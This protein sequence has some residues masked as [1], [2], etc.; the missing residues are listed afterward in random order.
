MKSAVKAAQI[1]E[2]N[3]KHSPILSETAILA[4]KTHFTYEEARAKGMLADSDKES[5]YT[6]ARSEHVDI[7]LAY[8]KG[9]PNSLMKR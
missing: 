5:D 4:A 3:E 2:W 9:K 7:T 8:I 6:V 1:V